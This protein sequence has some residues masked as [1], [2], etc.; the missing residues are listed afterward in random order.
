MKLYIILLPFFVL[1]VATAQ[2]SS[3]I[4]FGE[5]TRICH[6]KES[7]D[8]DC[9]TAPHQIYAPDPQYPEKE[10]KARHRGTVVVELVVD[11]DGSTRNVTVIRP[12]SRDF[13]QAAV[14]AVR[15]WKFSPATRDGQPVAV[16]IKAEVSFHLY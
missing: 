9:I 2:E 10:R 4:V 3:P 16:Q 5:N 12:L 13:D 14:D 8:R 7:D 11:T 1:S 15:N 6:A